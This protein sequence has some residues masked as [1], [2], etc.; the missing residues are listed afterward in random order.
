ML[1]F[2][3]IEDWEASLQLALKECVPLTFPSMLRVADPEYI[4]DARDVLFDVAGRDAVIDATIAWLRSNTLVG[5]HGTRLASE[6]VAAIQVAGLI[7]LLAKA[8]R[9]RLIRAL[10]PHP[11]WEEAK[12]RLDDVLHRIG[13]QG[14]AGKR[15]GQV[16]L[17]LSRGGLTTGF[18][19]Y[20]RY[21]AEFDYHA[22]HDL[23]GEE[24]QSLLATDGDSTLIQVGVPGAIALNAAHPYFSADTLR[25]REDVPNIV[26][27]FLAAWAYRFRKPSFQP[28]TQHIDCGMIFYEAVPAD[29]IIEVEKWSESA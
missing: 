8:R 3:K 20:L 26:G 14:Q 1:D 18:N 9:K 13:V 15:E 6:E 21:G 10:S 29:W 17:T 23:L 2:D 27:D 4:E 22:A 5:Y 25:A 7:P 12:T 16:H 24:G 28:G 11:A 19:H